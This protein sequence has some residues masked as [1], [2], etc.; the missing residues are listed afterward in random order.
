MGVRE[1]LGLHVAGLVEVALHKA[2]AAAKGCHRLAHGGLVQFRD[3]VLGTGD[4]E[5][6]PATA[7]RGLDGNG[8]PVLA[9]E[10]V[11]FLRRLNGVRGS[12]DQW[13]TS[14]LRDVACAD[15]VAEALD[16]GWGRSDPDEPGVD[17]GLG[18]QCVLGKEPVAGV[19]GVSAR[20]A[21]YVEQLVDVEVRVLRS[22]SHECEGLVGE[23]NVQGV[24]IGI[25][26]HCDACDTVVGASADDADSDL[27]TVGDEDLLYCGHCPTVNL[28]RGSFHARSR[29]AQKIGRHLKGRQGRL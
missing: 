20:T 9:G 3:F 10:S 23:L 19:H 21:S 17:D 26:V 13:R 18:E 16:R 25:C 2:L 22:G 15:L 11:D 1:A 12:R 24:P 28:N 5:A 7:E 29:G 4:L 27:A 8:E 6:T 14:A